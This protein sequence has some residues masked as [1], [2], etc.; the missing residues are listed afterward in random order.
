MDDSQVPMMIVNV[1]RNKKDEENDQM[2][3][4]IHRKVAYAA[5]NFISVLA[6]SLWFPYSVL[7]F[8]RVLNLS[9]K[10]AGYIIL[11]GQAGGAASTP[12]I[13][14]WSDLCYCRVPGRR[15]VFHL[16]GMII[17]ALVFFFLWHECLGCAGTS[18]TNK[19]IY[20]GVF[21]VLFQFGWAA[22]QIG[23]L[24]LL[25]ELTSQKKTMVELNSLRYIL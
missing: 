12:L 3:L 17:I 2:L 4:K 11:I 21:A 5:G 6:I 18:E 20:Y 16:M 7:F 24:A 8:H 19:V 25:P 10:N 14:F 15:K 9:P 23:Q 22:T 13:G 1:G